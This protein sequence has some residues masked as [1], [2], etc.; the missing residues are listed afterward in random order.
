MPLLEHEANHSQLLQSKAAPYPQYLGLKQKHNIFER[1]Q[2][3]R[4]LTKGSNVKKGVYNPFRLPPTT[5]VE[6]DLFLLFGLTLQLNSN[7][8]KFHLPLPVL[9]SE[10]PGRAGCSS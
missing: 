3:S 10:E 6:D 8:A 4:I 9:A 2:N 1:N 5:K 7:S